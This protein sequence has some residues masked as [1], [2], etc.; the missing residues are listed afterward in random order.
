M[1]DT[2]A[3]LHLKDPE[4]IGLGDF[5]KPTDYCARQIS[6]W[7]KQYKL[8]ET[9]THAADG[10]ADRMASANDPAAA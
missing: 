2:M 3:D 4:A 9:E 10:A 8:S 5:G 7:S 1:I 6:R